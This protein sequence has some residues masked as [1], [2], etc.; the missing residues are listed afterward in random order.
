MAAQSTDIPP[1]PGL[2]TTGI[3][4]TR[5]RVSVSVTRTRIP[6][7]LIPVLW[8]LVFLLGGVAVWSSIPHSADPLAAPW[9][10]SSDPT[11][12]ARQMTSEVHANAGGPGLLKLEWPAHPDARGYRIR[13]HDTEGR[14]LAPVTVQSSV[15]LYDLRSDV[16][17]L[18][19]SFEW[20]V[21]AVLRDGTEVVTPPQVHSTK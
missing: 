6:G 10:A 11:M 12:A 14:A 5:A 20:E 9:K 8:G 4:P 7:A 21:S 1:S 2:A 3:R 18:P 19:D 17:G 13:F 16:L 15:F